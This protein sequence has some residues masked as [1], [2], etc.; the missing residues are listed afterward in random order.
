MYLRLLGMGLAAALGWAAGCGGNVVVDGE[1]AGGSGGTTTTGP[2]GPTTTT[3]P[4]GDPPT[5]CEALCGLLDQ[6]DCGAGATCV[7][8]CLDFYAATSDCS[9]EVDAYFSCV[10]ANSTDCNLDPVECEVALQKFDEC[11]NG[12]TGC[13]GSVE[14]YG[15]SDG[16]C[17]CKG[18]C[19]NQDV[20]V[21]CAPDP[22]GYYLCGCVMGGELVGTCQELNP[23]CDL[24]G[25]C[26]APYFFGFEE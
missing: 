16:S 19:N 17:G 10:I 6:L 21:D 9:A 20:S 4:G 14:C 25:G 8:D 12:T 26:C 5:T 2:G 1:G 15:G 22:S 24:Q 23:T 18:Y 7:S 13:T 11:L 3:G